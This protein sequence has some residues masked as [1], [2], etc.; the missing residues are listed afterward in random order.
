MLSVPA[1]RAEVVHVPEPPLSATLVQPEM[2]L[3]FDVNDT[4][5]VGV[6]VAGAT[7]TTVAVKVTD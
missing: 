6:P 2:A 5:P 1:G 4:V 3:P 7:A